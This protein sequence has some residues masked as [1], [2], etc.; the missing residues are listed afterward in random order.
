MSKHRRVRHWQRGQSPGLCQSSAW[1][2][3]GEFLLVSSREG[4]QAPGWMWPT[5][6]IAHHV[7]P[8]QSGLPG[9]TRGA[10]TGGQGD[11]GTGW[12]LA[13]PHRAEQDVPRLRVGRPACP[14]AKGTPPRDTRPVPAP[15]PP[16]TWSCHLGW[17]PVCPQTPPREDRRATLCPLTPRAPQEHT[18]QSLGRAHLEAAGVPVVPGTF[19]LFLLLCGGKTEG[20]SLQ[21][22]RSSPQPRKQLPSWQCPS[23]SP[24]SST[25]LWSAPSRRPHRPASQELGTALPP[26][27]Q[28]HPGAGDT[29]PGA[30]GTSAPAGPGC[31][32]PPGAGAACWGR[33]RC[34]D[35]PRPPCTAR[36]AASRPRPWQRL[37]GQRGQLGWGD[38][39]TL[40]PVRPTPQGTSAGW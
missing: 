24:A 35:I 21:G 22:S 19:G 2:E 29:Y 26:C 34:R 4:A 40:P 23:H 30:A 17:L 33:R 18:R 39:A 38:T 15:Q 36:S 12:A 32:A 28:G 9:D 5:V 10:G 27:P 16:W 7:T 31:A 25:G 8:P 13:E 37:R 14:G 6:P 1:P 11:A 20:K 3:E